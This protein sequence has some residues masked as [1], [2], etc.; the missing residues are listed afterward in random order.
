MKKNLMSIIF[1]LIL[2]GILWLTVANTSSSL[3]VVVPYFNKSINVSLNVFIW[4]IFILGAVG[5]QGL[6]FNAADAKN[7]Q[8]YKKQY[9]KIAVSSE[10][11]ND[12]VKILEEKIKSL[13]IARE[14]A[15][16]K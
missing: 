8:S 15:L 12:R 1:I 3:N 4:A 5:V 10:E 9:E 16:Q 7:A 2:A 14:K 6:N 13:E 11:Q